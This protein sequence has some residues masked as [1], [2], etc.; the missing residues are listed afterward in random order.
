MSWFGLGKQRSKFGKW[1]DRRGITQQ[2]VA[3][4]SGVNRNTV[5]ELANNTDSK[6]SWKTRRKLDRGLRDAGFRSDDFWGPPI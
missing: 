4:R 6:P 3:E 2:E 1:L 5:G